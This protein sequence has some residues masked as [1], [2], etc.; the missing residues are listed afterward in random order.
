[1]DGA[2]FAATGMPDR[3]MDRRSI[4]ARKSVLPLDAINDYHLTPISGL[5]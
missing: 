4:N 2:I 5:Q 3:Q 1:M